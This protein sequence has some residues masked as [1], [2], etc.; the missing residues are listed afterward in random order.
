[1]ESEFQS[2]INPIRSKTLRNFLEIYYYAYVNKTKFSPFNASFVREVLDLQR[3]EGINRTYEA[4]IWP[5]IWRIRAIL[6][7]S[8]ATAQDYLRAVDIT[9]KY[10]IE[11]RQEFRKKLVDATECVK[12]V[13][14]K[15]KRERKGDELIALE[16]CDKILRELINRLT[17]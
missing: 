16:A 8:K 17:H 12:L 4:K 7:C 9:S 5:G 1:M 3:K 15:K 14:D 6:D 13:L 2:K 11:E 10:I